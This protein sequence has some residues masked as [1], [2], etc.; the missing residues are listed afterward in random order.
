MGVQVGRRTTTIPVLVDF[1]FCVSDH[2]FEVPTLFTSSAFCIR[3]AFGTE[4]LQGIAPLEGKWFLPWRRS[5]Q[6]P[7]AP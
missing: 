5:L 3:T 4:H 6:G 2:T 7:Y 1:P